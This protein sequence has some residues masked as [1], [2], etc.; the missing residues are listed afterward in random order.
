MAKIDREKMTRDFQRLGKIGRE[1]AHLGLTFAVALMLLVAATFSAIKLGRLGQAVLADDAA[2]AFLL[3]MGLAFFTGSFRFHYNWLYPGRSFE[4]DVVGKGPCEAQDYRQVRNYL[5]LASWQFLLVIAVAD[6]VGFLAYEA[7]GNF[8][9]CALLGGVCTIVALWLWSYTRP[10][11]NN[12]KAEASPLIRGTLVN[13]FQKAVMQSLTYLAHIRDGKAPG[14]KSYLIRWAG[15]D[16]PGDLESHF[17]II[18]AT[19]S[20]KTL[21]LQTLMRSVIPTI[22][23]ADPGATAR[24]ALVFDPENKFVPFLE[25]LAGKERVHILNPFD[26]RSRPWDLANEI[27]DLATAQEIASIFVPQDKDDSQKFWQKTARGILAAVL[28]A[29]HLKA[30]ERKTELGKEPSWTLRHV[31]HIATNE[32]R[33]TAVLRA[34]DQTQ[35]LIEVLK[36]TENTLFN[37]LAE[38]RSHMEMLEL[39]AALWDNSVRELRVKPFTLK[40][41]LSEEAILVIGMPSQLEET[42]QALNRVLI[43]RVSQLIRAAPESKEAEE[44]DGQDSVDDNKSE[45]DPIA[46][47][48]RTWIFIDELRNIGNLPG[49]NKLL[50]EGRSRGARVVITFQDIEGLR[51][52]YP[53]GGAEEITNQCNNISY[54]RCQGTTAKWA[55]ERLGRCEYWDRD[56]HSGI[57][58]TSGQS[59]SSTFSSG[60]NTRKNLTDAVLESELS[61]LPPIDKQAADGKAGGFIQG[62]HVVAAIECIYP[63]RAKEAWYAFEKMGDDRRFQKRLATDQILRPWDEEMDWNELGF[64]PESVTEPLMMPDIDALR[65]SSR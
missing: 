55:A 63:T 9:I 46:P 24:R 49:L 23:D 37:V 54:L 2:N 8:W 62:W 3:I 20:G 45:E 26:K 48:G 19:G 17:G 42:M 53:D 33:L 58:D 50:T 36:P 12:P 31:F 34:T 43:K 25:E 52:E 65:R 44:R 14:Q 13:T 10:H 7:T 64:R 38:L 60:S 27:D 29:L 28:K 39:V 21:A 5:I 40:G 41:W 61:G 11:L 6:F 32:K 22:R 57:S 56:Y 1:L 4:H 18:G 35:A 30:M 47:F 16:L 51:H 59:P 15:I